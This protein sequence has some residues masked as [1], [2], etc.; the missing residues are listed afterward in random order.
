[1]YDGICIEFDDAGSWIDLLLYDVCYIYM[2]IYIRYFI[3]PL[4]LVKLP[5]ILDFDQLYFQLRIFYAPLMVAINIIMVSST[6]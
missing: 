4:G 3:L 2:H 1:M 5:F 6:C